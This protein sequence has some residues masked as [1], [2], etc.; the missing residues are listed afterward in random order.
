MASCSVY[1]RAIATVIHGVIVLNLI[2]VIDVIPTD[3]VVCQLMVQYDVNRLIFLLLLFMSVPLFLFM[4]V[5]LLLSISVP[6]LPVFKL[7]L[8]SYHVNDA[9]ATATYDDIVD[10]DDYVDEYDFA[11]T[12]PLFIAF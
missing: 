9:A 7:F 2:L 3:D 6:L 8:C 1:I 4:S 12:A 5:P 10:N 11:P